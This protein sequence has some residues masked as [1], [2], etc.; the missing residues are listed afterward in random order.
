MSITIRAHR[1]NQKNRKNQTKN[2]KQVKK[3]ADKRMFL[4]TQL[5]VECGKSLIEIRRKR[6][7][8][9]KDGIAL[10]DNLESGVTQFNVDAKALLSKFEHGDAELVALW[11]KTREWSLTEF[12]E[13]YQWIDTCFDHNCC[14]L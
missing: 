11:K 1:R 3:A 2:K 7:V 6:D 14:E 9:L 12:A 5:K 8:C 4:L 10:S 13:I